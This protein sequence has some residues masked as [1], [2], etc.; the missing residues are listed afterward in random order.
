[1]GNSIDEAKG[2]AKGAAG[3]LTGDD[4]LKREG[5]VDKAAGKVKDAVDKVADKAKNAGGRDS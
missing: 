5:S 4:D 3:E 2:R 1:V